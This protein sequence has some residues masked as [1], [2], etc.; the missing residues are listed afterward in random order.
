MIWGCFSANGTGQIEIIDGILDSNGYLRILEEKMLPSAV[1]LGIEN[2][3]IFQDDSAPIH[4]AKKVK[5]WMSDRNI[6]HL[7]WPGN[8]P[9]LNPIENLWK[10]LKQKV[11]KKHPK[12]L[13]DL[14]ETIFSVWRNELPKDLCKKLALSMKTRIS[15]V[16]KNKGGH[17]K[18]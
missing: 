11:M 5:K 10:H 1:D 17:I 7:N 16:L 2:D 3:Y 9:D 14:K 4:R 12:S 13:A 6:E 8:S 18:Y 15:M